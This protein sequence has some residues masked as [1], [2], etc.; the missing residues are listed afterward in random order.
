M[1]TSLFSLALTIPSQSCTGGVSNYQMWQFQPGI[2][3]QFQQGAFPQFSPSYGGSFQ[4]QVG[5][6]GVP[7]GGIPATYAPQCP[8]PA[9]YFNA[10][11]MRTRNIELQLF[12][13]TQN[14]WRS[15]ARSPL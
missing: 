15:P 2:A 11:R 6:Q 12:P 5:P 1:Y 9:N 14:N 10:S 7:F 8:E 4:W 13:R 3:W